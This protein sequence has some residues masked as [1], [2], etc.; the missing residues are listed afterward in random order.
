MP[1]EV[2]DGERS[3]T[4]DGFGDEFDDFEEG[5]ETEDFGDFDDENQPQSIIRGRDTLDEQFANTQQLPL[6]PSALSPFVSFFNVFNRPRSMTLKNSR[7]G[8]RVVLMS[9]N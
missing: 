9:E 1:Q 5:A 6:P 3:D 8:P 2:D 4:G 7:E